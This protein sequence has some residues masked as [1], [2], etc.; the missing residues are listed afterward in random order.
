[1][2]VEQD[3]ELE[4]QESLSKHYLDNA[5]AFAYEG[6]REGALA[7]IEL[8]RRTMP[9]IASV[10]NYLG[11]V[12]G[13]LD[14]LESAIEAYQIAVQLNPR[15]YE[16]RENLANARVNLEEN[17]YLEKPSGTLE[18]SPDYSDSELLDAG[19]DDRPVPGWIYLDEKGFLLPGWPGHR[20]RPGR[21]GY[22]PLD[23]D[24]EYA[25]M[26]GR[27]L[28]M[29]FT[30]RMR[31]YS[32]IYLLFMTLVGLMYS[33]PML[34]TIATVLNGELR[35]VWLMAVFSVDFAVGLALLANVAASVQNRYNDGNE[36]NGSAFF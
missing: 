29:L 33:L 5:L 18:A 12:F 34:L 32:T 3:I 11:Q 23:S 21:S 7:E 10:Y 9:A 26:Q 35:Y 6:E 8:A 36:Y 20:T 22:D 24:F 28:R 25:Q 1:M 30:I 2:S 13:I 31:T 19:G 15:Y 14:Q 27:I 16:A 17:R 4:F